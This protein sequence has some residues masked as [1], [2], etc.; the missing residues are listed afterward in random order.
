MHNQQEENNGIWSP[1]SPELVNEQEKKEKNHLPKRKR[2][3]KAD[4]LIQNKKSVTAEK[5]QQ[6]AAAKKTV[7]EYHRTNIARAGQKLTR[8]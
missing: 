5:I 7:Q 4:M 8:M 3:E 1:T 6:T 2:K